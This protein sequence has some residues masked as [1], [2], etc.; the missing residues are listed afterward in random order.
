MSAILVGLWFLMGI[1]GVTIC[2]AADRAQGEPVTYGLEWAALAG[3]M[4]FIAAVIH[5]VESM[6][7]IAKSR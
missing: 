4:L 5:A 6:N 2:N 3:P 7:E 1:G